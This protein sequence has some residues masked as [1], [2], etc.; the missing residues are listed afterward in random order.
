MVLMQSHQ[1]CTCTAILKEVIKDY[2]P[3]QEFWLFS[4]ERYNGIIGKQPTNNRNIESQL[5]NC[6]LNDNVGGAFIYPDK[7][8]QA[9]FESAST[10]QPVGSGLDVTIGIN[11]DYTNSPQDIVG[12]CFRR[13]K[14]N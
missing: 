11:D 1:T 13:M 2:G 8:K 14:R 6:F 3:M 9:V 4:S 12:Q 5:M 10:N 7:F